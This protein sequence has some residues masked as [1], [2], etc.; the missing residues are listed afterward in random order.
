M[1]KETRAI[2]LQFYAQIADLTYNISFNL[3]FNIYRVK[4]KVTLPNIIVAVIILTQGWIIWNGSRKETKKHF[5]Q[6]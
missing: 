2:Q 3:W 5:T 1:Q 6:F 4:L